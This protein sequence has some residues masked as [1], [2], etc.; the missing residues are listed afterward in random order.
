MIEKST[1]SLLLMLE[2]VLIIIC[3][4]LG[5]D[6]T[7]GMICY[8]SIVAINHLTDYIVRRIENGGRKN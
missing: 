3:L 7:V 1:Q 4:G 2:A 6:A 5:E 8:W